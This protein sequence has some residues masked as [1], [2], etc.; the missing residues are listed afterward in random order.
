MKRRRFL[1]GLTATGLIAS[2][3][4][5]RARTVESALDQPDEG[6][7]LPRASSP[8]TLKGEMLYRT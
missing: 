5:V 1:N 8:G 4:E 3:A 6:V 2:L 7:A